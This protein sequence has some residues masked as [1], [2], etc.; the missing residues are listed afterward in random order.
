MVRNGRVSHHIAAGKRDPPRREQAERL[1]HSVL[2]RAIANANPRMSELYVELENC[3]R[4]AYGNCSYYPLPEWAVRE[5][6]A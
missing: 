6:W 2:V 1:V 4:Y 5:G 3:S